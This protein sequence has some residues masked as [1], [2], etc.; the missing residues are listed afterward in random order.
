MPR[1]VR[2][3]A[4]LL[5]VCTAVEARAAVALLAADGGGGSG[6]PGVAVVP[7]A[8]AGV[9]LVAGERRVVVDALFGDGL[10]G[11]ATLAPARRAARTDPAS[12]LRES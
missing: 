3:L 4:L 1:L 10:P 9:L 5:A 7:L 11:Y 12:V 2:A 6:A 8:N